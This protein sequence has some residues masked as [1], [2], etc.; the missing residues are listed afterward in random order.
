M[1][2]TTVKRE[3]AWAVRY[4]ISETIAWRLLQ[5]AVVPLHNWRAGLLTKSGDSGTSATVRGI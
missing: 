3:P 5:L 4:S 1:A 2:W